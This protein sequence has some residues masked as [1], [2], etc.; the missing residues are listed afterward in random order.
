M[1]LEQLR[2]HLE[3][4][5]KL[6]GSLGLQTPPVR[7]N[8]RGLTDYLE[9]K[10]FEWPIRTQTILDWIDAA[11]ADCGLYG[12]KMR[13]V[14]ARCFLKHLQASVPDTECARHELIAESPATQTPTLLQRGDCQT[15]ASDFSAMETRLIVASDAVFDHRLACQHRA[16]RWRRGRSHG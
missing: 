13:L 11:S 15:S 9:G 10:E 5:L 4:Y 2:L 3:D 8:L 14:H 6:R 1:T 12:Q 7:Y 16:S